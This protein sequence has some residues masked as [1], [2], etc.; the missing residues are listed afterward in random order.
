MFWGRKEKDALISDD[1]NF[2]EIIEK[3]KAGDRE[4][5]ERFI[6]D[7]RPFILGCASKHMKKYIEI[8]NSEEFSIAMIAFDKAIDDFSNVKGKHFLSFA[9]LVIKRRLI[10]YKKKEKNYSNVI[11]FSYFEEEN[12]AKMKYMNDS[13]I[14]NFDR[15]ETRQEMQLFVQKLGEYGIGLD[16]LIKKTPKHKDSKQLLISIAKIISENDN[17]YQKLDRKKCI[18]MT[19]LEQ[20]LSVSPKTVEKNRKYIIATCIALRSDLEIIKGFVNKF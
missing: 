19:D 12:D 3:I 6:Y 20:Y 18:P 5:R 15:F 8:E 1:G 14:L 7:Y 17:L 4:L 9:D 11:P 10:N 2:S 16:D 13:V